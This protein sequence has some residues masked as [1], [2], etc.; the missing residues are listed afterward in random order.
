MYI[1]Q[2]TYSQKLLNLINLNYNDF[3]NIT[4]LFQDGNHY[5]LTCFLINVTMV[6]TPKCDQAHAL[7]ST[8]NIFI[9]QCLHICDHM[10]LFKCPISLVNFV[11]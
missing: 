6:S 4:I 10:I 1:S 7:I 9:G 3:L 5:T 8:T 11:L 2:D